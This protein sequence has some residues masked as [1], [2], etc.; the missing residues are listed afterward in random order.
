MNYG[1]LVDIVLVVVVVVKEEKRFEE[2]FRDFF[3]PSQ[4]L[5]EVEI[6]RVY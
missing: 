3:K 1:V 6:K 4:K 2:Y 5:E